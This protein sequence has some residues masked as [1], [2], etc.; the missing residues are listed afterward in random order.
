MLVSQH[1]ARADRGRAVAV[2]EIAWGLSS[3]VGVPLFGLLMSAGWSL[4]WLGYAAFGVASCVLLHCCPPSAAAAAG[5]EKEKEEG[6]QLDEQP[7]QPEREQLQLQE[8][9]QDAVALDADA[10]TTE[11][12]AE[13][14]SAAAAGAY[15]SSRAQIFS[16]ASSGC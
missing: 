14:S 11:S 4:P 15:P 3:L 13:T 9:E 8:Q 10:G 7:E 6:Q 1:V 2:I 5:E 16:D 12:V